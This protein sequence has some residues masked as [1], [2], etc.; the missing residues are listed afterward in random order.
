MGFRPGASKRLHDAVPV[1]R[2]PLGLGDNHR[3][4]P[5]ESQVP[6]VALLPRDCPVSACTPPAAESS[7]PPE[8]ANFVSEP[9]DPG[10][11]SFVTSWNLLSCSFRTSALKTLNAC[12]NHTRPFRSKKPTSRPVLRSGPRSRCPCS[13]QRTVPGLGETDVVQNHL[14]GARQE[15]GRMDRGWGSWCWTPGSRRGEARGAGRGWLGVRGAFSWGVRARG[16]L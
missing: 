4:P 12:R 15:A 1:E 13:P 14:R 7:P 16:S 8:E 11:A 6:F 9:P 10:K 5:A 3:Y 2:S